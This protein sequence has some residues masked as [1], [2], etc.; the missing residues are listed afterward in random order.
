MAVTLTAAA[1]AA[2]VRL[3]DSTEETAEATRLLAYATEA[4][5]KHAPDAPDAAHDEAAIRVAGYLFDQP[6]AARGVGAADALRNSGARA[7]LLPYR[8]HRAGNVATEATEATD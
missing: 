6:F 3:G 8:V 5:T 2:A 4:V 7:I 1:L